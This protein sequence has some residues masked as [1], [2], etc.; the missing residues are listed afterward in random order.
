MVTF[1]ADSLDFVD[2][3]TVRHGAAPDF[4]WGFDSTNTRF[5]L[6]DLVNGVTAYV[7]Q[8]RAGDLVDGR[9]AQAVAE[10]KIL[11]DD[12]NVYDDPNN[13]RNNAGS[14]IKIGPGR[15]DGIFVDVDG[16]TVLGSGRQTIIDGNSGNAFRVEAND[17]TIRNLVARNNQTAGVVTLRQA[18]GSRLTVDSVYITEGDEPIRA[19]NKLVLVNS[20]IE[21]CA[22]R[23]STTGAARHIFANNRIRSIGNRG[24][25]MGED[26]IAV[27]N[28]I[29]DSS[30]AMGSV[31]LWNDDSIAIANRV[32]RSRTN[33]IRIEGADC[34]VANNRVSDSANSDISDNGTGTVLDANLTGSAN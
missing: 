18:S 10:G 22:S 13:A 7:Q 33:G 11:A 17:V 4:E 30:D 28:H 12:G 31:V 3:E 34:I 27:G 19:S 24:L 9:L 29:S 16:L 32:E 20:R 1:N 21:N 26:S 23:I 8:N 6:T 14:W 25:Y 5:E 15:F 2:D